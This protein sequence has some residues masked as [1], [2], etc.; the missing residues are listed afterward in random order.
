MTGD[1]I[2]DEQGDFA[3]GKVCVDLIFTINQIG[4]SV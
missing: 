4:E 2:D 3:A 1:L